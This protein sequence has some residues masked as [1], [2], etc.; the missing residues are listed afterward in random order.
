M[1]ELIKTPLAFEHTYNHFLE[2]LRMG[3][4]LSQMIP[5]CI[6][7]HAGTFFTLLPKN[8]PKNRVYKFESGLLSHIEKN[9]T[10]MF[11][12]YRPTSSM[13]EQLSHHIINFLSSGTNKS[14]VFSNVLQSPGDPNIDLPDTITAYYNSE[15]YY[16]FQSSNVPLDVMKKCIFASG[17]GWHFLAILT[18]NIPKINQTINIELMNEILINA[19]EIV[20]GAYDDEGYIFWEKAK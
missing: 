10:H 18:S 15:I 7:I 19:S 20:I 1:I 2:Y 3:N 11:E 16:A 14:A 5:S 9:E 4:T 13:D 17:M 8:T 6:D 12:Y